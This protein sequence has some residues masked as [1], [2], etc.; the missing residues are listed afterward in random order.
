[1]KSSQIHLFWGHLCQ[2]IP[3][4]WV[5]PLATPVWDAG[6]MWLSNGWIFTINLVS[7]SNKE[8][9]IIDLVSFLKNEFLKTSIRDILFRF[10]NIWKTKHW[11]SNYQ[12]SSFTMK[13]EIRNLFELWIYIIHKN[14]NE[15]TNYRKLVTRLYNG[16]HKPL[17]YCWK[18][19]FTLRGISGDGVL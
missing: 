16:Y 10:F 1:M 9:F 4:K 14:G 15:N 11:S 12:F 7:F 13:N 19:V 18:N 8:I 2:Q 6:V 17:A 5:P 3:R